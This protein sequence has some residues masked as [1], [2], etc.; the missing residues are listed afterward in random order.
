MAGQCTI[1]IDLGGTNLRGGV[2]AATG[3]L[4][5]RRSIETQAERG[6]EHVFSLLVQLVED[7]IRDAGLTKRQIVGVGY[8]TPGPASYKRGLI[9]ATANLP[10]WQ[11]VPVRDRL[12]TAT[13]LPVTLDNDAN[14]AAFGEFVAGAGRG[15]RDMVMLTLGTGVGGGV[16]ANG[17]L[18]HGA[19]ENAGEIGHMIIVPDGRACPCGQRGCLERYGSANAV[20]ERLAEAIRAGEGSMVADRVLAGNA[21]TSVD[22]AEAA[23]AGDPLAVRIWDETCYYLAIAAVNMQHVLNPQRFVLAGGLIG[24]GEQLLDPVR[25]H[26]RRQT[27]H[28]AEDFPQ[29][30]FATLGGDAGIIGAAALARAEQ[31][32]ESPH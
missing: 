23:R 28:L 3:G 13:G 32:K 31:R 22:V 10:G 30:E 2:L 17:E 12:A 14:A 20:A 16:I 15:V 24:A 27:W 18:L 25:A 21:V 8:G 4:V 5:C 19:L 7:L 9:Y 29:I 1:G 11:D 26:F 6:F